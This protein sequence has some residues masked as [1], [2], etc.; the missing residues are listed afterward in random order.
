MKTK[1]AP[2]DVRSASGKVCNVVLAPD[3]TFHQK[4]K[5]APND[6]SNAPGMV[7]NVV[8]APDFVLPVKT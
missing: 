8:L 5:I 3:F 6:V 1:I 2:N 7:C 4:I